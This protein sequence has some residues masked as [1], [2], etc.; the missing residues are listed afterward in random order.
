M[1]TKKIVASMTADHTLLALSAGALTGGVLAGG[2]YA[3]VNPT[4]PLVEVAQVGAVGAVVG[5]LGGLVVSE[6][7]SYTSRKEA[8]A[9][10]VAV[11]QSL[12]DIVDT[13]QSAIE[14]ELKQ[15][16]QQ[17]AATNDQ[18]PVRSPIAAN[19]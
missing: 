5:A 16:A 11:V 1:K 9:N 15:P 19:G 7:L 14:A 10:A 18:N 2:I 17:Q 6:T 3:A 13:A 8:A 12:V 4:A